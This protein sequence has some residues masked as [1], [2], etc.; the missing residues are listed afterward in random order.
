MK[1]LGSMSLGTYK[2]LALVVGKGAG[3]HPPPHDTQ[4]LKVSG[5]GL[6]GNWLRETIMSMGVQ[7]S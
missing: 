6:S 3:S 2:F 4:P 5:P 7:L 1:D